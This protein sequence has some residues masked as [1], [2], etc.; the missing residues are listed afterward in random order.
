MHEFQNAVSL[1]SMG[2]VAGAFQYNLTLPT[3]TIPIQGI[4]LNYV[5]TLY[6]VTT[7]VPTLNANITT[8]ITMGPISRSNTVTMVI[9]SS[10]QPYRIIAYGC[11]NVGN[12]TVILISP[13][14]TKRVCVWRSSTVQVGDAAIG[15]AKST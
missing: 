11:S 10:T 3:S 15:V 2:V 7:G 13:S 4:T 5:V 8:T 14:A 9:Y 12:G 1:A 6:T